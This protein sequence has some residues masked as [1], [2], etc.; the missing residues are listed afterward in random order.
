MNLNEH[1]ETTEKISKQQMEQNLEE[2]VR[3]IIKGEGVLESIP[4]WISK[5]EQMIYPERYEAWEEFVTAAT[6]DLYRALEV[7]ATLTIMEELETQKTIDEVLASVNDN[8]LTHRYDLVSGFVFQFSKR[9]PEFLERTLPPEK[10]TPEVIMEI[11]SKKGEN[12]ELSEKYR[13]VGNAK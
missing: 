4:E 3:T 12:A 10:L 13:K 1:M 11:E 9:G 8:P 2:T 6:T 5:G 7:P